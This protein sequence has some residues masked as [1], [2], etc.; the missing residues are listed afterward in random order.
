MR[1]SAWRSI[2]P[3]VLIVGASC[4]RGSSNTA[5]LTDDLQRDLAAASTASIQLANESQG[6]K[7][8]R[9]VSAIERGEDAVPV[10]RRPSPR[11][12]VRNHTSTE[13]AQEK[14]PD[15]SPQVAVEAPKAPEP[16]QPAPTIS[17]APTVPVVA[18]RPAP[19]P[20]D[21]PSS[22]G[23]SRGSVGAGG[24][25]GS[26]RSPGPDIGTIIGVI[27]RGGAIGDDHCVP[28]RVPRG[29]RGLPRPGFP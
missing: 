27:I 26:G 15:P 18:P 24:S 13:P 25:T 8:M 11:P 23:G 21:Y 14:A 3:V 28:R 17:D 29:P 10:Q 1:T 9:F 20:V 22:D 19:L 4:G 12:V 2:L 6:Y 7:P 5:K 16:Q